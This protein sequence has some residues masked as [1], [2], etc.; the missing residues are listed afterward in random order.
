[1]V[2]PDKKR[3]MRPLEK[4]IAKYAASLRG[5]FI[6]QSTTS[7]VNGQTV[8]RQIP[9]AEI[10]VFPVLSFASLFSF[11]DDKPDNVLDHGYRNIP[12]IAARYAI[13]HALKLMDV[14]PGD[15][16][17]LPAYHC[18]V[19]VEPIIEMGCK[20]V[21]YKITPELD[22]DISDVSKKITPKT[23]AIIAVNY[24]GFI[25][26]MADVKA[27]CETRK[28][29]L[30]E[31]CAHS[32]FGQK[33]GVTVGGHGDFILVSARKFFP[34]DEGGL[35]LI[36]QSAYNLSK[37]QSQKFLNT[38]KSILALIER[39]L[40]YKKLWLMAP[41]VEIF[42]FLKNIFKKSRKPYSTSQSVSNHNKPETGETS[43]N[44]DLMNCKAT[45]I[46]NLL[47][48]ILNSKGIT[49]SRRRNYRLLVDHFKSIPHCRLLIEKLPEGT[50]PF[51]FPVY[52]ENL[53]KYFPAFED[54]ALPMQRFAQ[55]L[56]PDM[57]E[58]TCPVTAD[59][60][61]NVILFP[62]HQALSE[63]DILW[64]VS[65]IRKILEQE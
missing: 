42:N 61:K 53:E 6:S 21:F 54:A 46:N 36:R 45:S 26:N 55:F 52:I 28:I 24:C 31:D 29:T 9:E 33:N 19:M 7:K 5:H 2:K 3:N 41:F 11:L 44:H 27:L 10:P 65:K 16:I 64:L 49:K 59:Y 47:P 35:L 34:V 17:L 62:C 51:M 25:Q 63:D 20:P 13:A 23:K 1:M 60:S 22:T 32:F 40:K 57:A 38:L 48:K 30:T 15:E 8:F 50:V 12:V 4:Y 58:N 39:A 43:Y 14:S 18:T 56:W 37:Q